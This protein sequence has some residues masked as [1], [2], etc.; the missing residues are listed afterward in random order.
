MKDEEKA[1]DELINELVEMRQQITELQAL[2]RKCK[3]AEE[4]L[5]RS[6]KLKALG[7]MAGGVAHD[8]NNL[9]AIILG[10]AQLLEKGLKRY[11]SEEIK[12]RLR[13]IARTA[14]EGGETVRRLQ[15]FSPRKVPSQDF[16]KIDLNEIVRFAIASTS[17]RWKDEAEAKGTAIRIKEKLGKLPPLLGSRSGLMEVLTNLIF[18]ALEA[19]SEGGEITIRTEAKE[20]KVYLYFTDSS[21]GIPDRIKKKIFDP[22]FTTKGPKA[23]GLGLSVSYGIIK[24]HQGKIKVESTEG[25]GTTFI[26]S[27]PIRLEAVLKKEKLEAPEKISS[28]KILVIDNEE[29]IRDVLGEIFQDEGHRI[30]LAETS[31]KGL[32]KFKQDNFDLVLTDLGMSEMSGWEL[33]KKI[34]EID[35]S[36][37][38]GVI[39][40]WGPTITKEK[41]KEER[42]DFILSKPFDCTKVL[43]EV[44]ALLKSKRRQPPPPQIKERLF[45]GGLQTKAARKEKNKFIAPPASIPR[46]FLSLLQTSLRPIQIFLQDDR[47]YLPLAQIRR[48][49]EKDV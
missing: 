34:K 14:Y 47:F 11:E 42:V 9:L 31:R 15:H 45:R 2:E 13:I 4:T 38:V 36:I 23:S 22:F 26:I 17:P 40:G 49:F 16:T 39:T 32:D 19:M 20:N 37:P 18:N 48:Y 5:I 35:P 25:K 3:K 27:I 24:R 1:K 43:R 44:N 28:Q 8:F 21:K 12:H 30:T 33:A 46:I 10:N 41:M 29:G 6:E 7:E